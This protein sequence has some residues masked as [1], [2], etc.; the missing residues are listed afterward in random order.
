MDQWDGYMAARARLTRFLSQG[1]V[2]NPIIVSGDTHASW[3]NEVKADFDDP[4]S[5]VVAAEL[6]GPSITSKSGPEFVARVQ[7][8]LTDNPHIRFF[9]GTRHGYV[10]C[11][12][13]P[14][15]LRADYR[16]VRSVWE[17]SEVPSTLAAVEIEDGSP[18][19]ALV[20]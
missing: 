19:P 4:N 15:V 11:H 3:V 16:V 12:A 6:G 18:E 17:P 9:E 2:R 8:A 7:K 1:E 20:S 5:P 10:R 14:D 13:A